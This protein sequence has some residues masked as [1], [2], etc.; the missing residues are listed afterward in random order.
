[1][2]TVHKS[3]RE[4]EATANL[5]SPLSSAAGEEAERISNSLIEIEGR[6]TLDRPIYKLTQMKGSSIADKPLPERLF[7]VL[8]SVKLLT[9]QVAM[10]LDAE[11]RNRI[12]EQLDDLLDAKD[13]H[14]DDDPLKASS[15]ETFLRM[16]IFHNLTR[17]PGVGQSNRGNLIAAWTTGSDRLTIEFLR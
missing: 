3:A 13:W 10:H 2:S 16:I 6:Q 15:F 5:L 17:R 8:A 14:E 7:D 4:I 1:M 9:A 12:F 11:W